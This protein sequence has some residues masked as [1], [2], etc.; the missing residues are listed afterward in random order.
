MQNF[1]VELTILMRAGNVLIPLPTLP[2]LLSLIDAAS[3]AGGADDWPRTT[4]RVEAIN[5]VKTARFILSPKR[6]RC[7]DGTS[8]RLVKLIVFRKTASLW[9]GAD[10][11][12]G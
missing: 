11:T 7:D 4:L 3:N 8:S 12:K 6:H 10:S 9:I 2:G 5:A 1:R